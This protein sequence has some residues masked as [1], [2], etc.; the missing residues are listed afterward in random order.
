[1]ILDI[2]EGTTKEEL[3]SAY[4]SYVLEDNNANRTHTAD[5]AGISLRTVRNYLAMWKKRP[6]TY[7]R[8]LLKVKRLPNSGA[9]NHNV[10][11]MP[12]AA[13]DKPTS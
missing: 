7:R 12:A 3:V 10:R 8:S 2:Q 6:L 13:L 4:L 1:M 11:A 5:A 9:L